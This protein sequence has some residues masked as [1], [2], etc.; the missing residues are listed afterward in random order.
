[1][2]ASDMDPPVDRALEAFNDHD[3]DALLDEFA[4]DGTFVDPLLDEAV[5][6]EA[7][8]EYTEEIFTG[9]PDV[10]FEPNRVITSGDGAHAI[11]ATYI[12]THEGPIEG[13]P[14]TGKSV[15]VESMTVIDVSDEGITAWRDYWDQ[16]SF[17]D[18]LGLGFPAI[19]PLL[20]KI[21]VAKL[22]GRT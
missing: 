3:T 21:L 11:E 13:I 15:A 5:T 10:S 7:L 19:V 6:G 16:Q 4:P 18:Q 8:R 9:F 12:G 17:S 2:V 20:P 14:P 1:M 22:T